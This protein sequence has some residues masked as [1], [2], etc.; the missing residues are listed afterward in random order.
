MEPRNNKENLCSQFYS[1]TFILYEGN[2]LTLL[3][4]GTVDSGQ[5][6]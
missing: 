3:L 2:K 4:S 1:D 5:K 6:R